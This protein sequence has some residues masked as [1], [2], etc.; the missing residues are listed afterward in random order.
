[1]MT[2]N[3]K[4]KL[5]QPF[6]PRIVACQSGGAPERRSGGEGDS[7]SLPFAAYEASTFCWWRAAQS[8][9]MRVPTIS[10]LISPNGVPVP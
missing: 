9:V 1:M 5:T 2:T 8:T 3:L 7:T 10:P 6:C 4:R